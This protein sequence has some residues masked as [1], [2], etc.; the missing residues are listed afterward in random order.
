MHIC[1]AGGAAVSTP[2]R[3]RPR[4][5]VRGRALPAAGDERGRRA[6]VARLYYLDGLDQGQIARMVGTSRSTVSR[7]LTEARERGIVRISIED[8]DARDRELEAALTARL[9]LRRAVV[10]RRMGGGVAEVRRTI[11]HVAAPVFGEELRPR[12]VVGVAGGRTLA[13]LIRR[14]S[15]VRPIADLRV[16]QLMGNIGA[17]PGTIDAVEL[18][19]ALAERFGGVHYTLSA[20]AHVQTA[21]ARRLLL[22]HGH[23]Q[24]LWELFGAMDLALVGIGTLADSAFI[25]RGVVAE[26]ALRRLGAEGAVGEVCGRFFDRQGHEC[27]AEYRERVIGVDLAALRRCPD[28]VGVTNGPQRAE[29]ARAAI[30]SGLVKS[31][32]IDDEGARAVLEHRS[33]RSRAR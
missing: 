32:V 19:R 26:P 2:S 12:M 27:G 15:T 17:S 14:A 9:G 25:E 30:T 11:G 1:A 8:H 4:A 10:V 18:S 33:G 7:L 29:A 20:P 16:V 23:M 21:A 28:V 22:A 5:V 31:L 24:A 3:A 6:F 13:E